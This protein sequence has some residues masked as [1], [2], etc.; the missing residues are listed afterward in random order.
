[1]KSNR[2]NLDLRCSDLYW[3]ITG[4][5]G[6]RMQN[7]DKTAAAKDLQFRQNFAKKV[8][9]KFHEILFFSLQI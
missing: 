8:F 1:M 9:H 5:G 7:W 2:K 6:H 4:R 3:A